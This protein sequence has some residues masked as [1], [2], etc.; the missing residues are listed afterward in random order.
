MRSIQSQKQHRI[1]EST[2]KNGSEAKHLKVTEAAQRKRW[3]FQCI[4]STPQASNGARARERWPLL[5]IATHWLPL[6]WLS[7]TFR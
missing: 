6:A 5:S 7:F 2:W 4:G 1:Y 3:R